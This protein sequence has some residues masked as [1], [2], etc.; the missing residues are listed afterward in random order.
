MIVRNT[1]QYIDPE[2]AAMFKDKTVL[3]VDDSET[4]RSYLM[5]VIAPL[6][7]ITDGAA[8]G[9]EA[10]AKC[11]QRTGDAVY[12]LILLDLILPDADGIELLQHIRQT[13]TRSTIVMVTGHGGIK[14]AISATRLGAD[15]Y[16]LKQDLAATT[17]DHS[18]FIYALEQAFEH[19]AGVVAKQQLEEMRAEFY[20]MVTHDL[21]NPASIVYT[22]LNMITDDGTDNL[23]IQQKQCI[24]FAMEGLGK[25]MHLINDYLDYAKIDAGYLK[26]DPSDVD[27]RI[28]VEASTQLAS[29]QTQSKGQTLTVELPDEPV[30]ANAD[31]ERI[32]QVLDNLLSNAHKYTPE[33]GHIFVT[34]AAEA[35]SALFRVQDTGVGITPSQLSALFTKYHRI[36]GESTRGIVGTGLG[37]L[38]V[39][40][41]VEAHG[42]TIRAES[43]GV[44]G[45]GTT[46]IF[47]IPLAGVANNKTSPAPYNAPSDIDEAELQQIFL[48]EAGE[49]IAALHDLFRHLIDQPADDD[50]IRHAQRVVHTLK[51]NAGAV[52]VT[53]IYSLAAEMDY[54][55]TQSLKT[56]TPLNLSDMEELVQLLDQINMVLTVHK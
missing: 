14:S 53:E 32:K 46:F 45:K 16:L 23:T 13:N 51:G 33:G 52:Q 22:A 2:T 12:D 7:A 36:P 25:M 5:G 40:E 6:G 41:I 20:S 48:Q 8:T 19:R 29:L 39:K 28:I 54:I 21:R 17:R 24:T 43:E 26:L 10:L 15:G 34:L 37:L 35:D 50:V 42:G 3:I 4:I 9:E 1:H 56:G 11:G 49:Q 44:R 18:E 27:L 38:I 55:L 31:A 47:T 30:V